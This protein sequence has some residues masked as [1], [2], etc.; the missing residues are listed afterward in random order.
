VIDPE[1][2]VERLVDRVV[3]VDQP[4]RADAVGI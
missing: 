2:V 3:A 1:L 4:R